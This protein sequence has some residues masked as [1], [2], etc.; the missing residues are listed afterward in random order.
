MIRARENM[1]GAWTFLIGVIVATVGGIV[2]SFG[3]GVNPIILAILAV[4]GFVAGFTVD[5]ESSGGNKFLMSAVALVIVSFA[6][7]QG[8][9]GVQFIGINIGKIISSTLAGLLVMLVPATMVVAIKNLFSLSQ[10]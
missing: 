6:G 7:Q 4:L 8:I 1:M 5:V 3:Y 2:L 10:R 9:A